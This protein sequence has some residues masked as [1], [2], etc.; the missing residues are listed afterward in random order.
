MS[1]SANP[2]YFGEILG[3][4]IAASTWDAIPATVRN[5]GKRSLLNFISTSVGSKRLQ[6]RLTSR[7]SRFWGAA[8]DIDIINLVVTTVGRGKN[9]LRIFS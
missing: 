8:R 3:R 5:E 6:V 7:F 9:S 1:A 2:R 4:F